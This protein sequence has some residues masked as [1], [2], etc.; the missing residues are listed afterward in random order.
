MPD[1][2]LTKWRLTILSY[3]DKNGEPPVFDEKCVLASAD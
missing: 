2:G 1:L 3:C